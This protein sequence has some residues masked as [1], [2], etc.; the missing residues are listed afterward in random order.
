M[1]GYILKMFPRFSETFILTEI[2]E[3]EN[4]GHGVAVLSLK[5]PDDGRFHAEQSQ[6][7]AK[8][9]YLP[10]LFRDAPRTFL[11][12]HIRMASRRPKAYLSCLFTAM[13]LLGPATASFLYAPMAAEVAVSSGW[14]HIHAHFANLPAVTALFTARLT[15]LP[16][17][18]TA[19][20]KDIFIKG[21]SRPL[22]RLLFREATRV[23]TVSDY[24]L[25]YL[26]EIQDAATTHPDRIVRI[27]NGIDL[28]RFLPGND[29]H[30]E[31]RP[32]ILAIGRL[33]EKKGFDDLLEACRI[34]TENKISYRCR[35][36]GKGPL[37]EALANRISTLGLENDVA[38]CGP[39]PRGEIAR[40]LREAAILAAPCVEAGDG[41]R[42]GLPTVVLEAAAS[43][44]PVVA[45]E[46]TGMREAVV[47]GVTGR[48][49]APGSPREFAGA[50]EELLMDRDARRSMGLRARS[51]IQHKFDLR[52]SV[53][54]L[55]TLFHHEGTSAQPAADLARQAG[56]KAAV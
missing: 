55:E 4:R 15:G 30:A 6:V 34:L 43:G 33:V 20:A 56:R 9:N 40:M 1:T 38:L 24:N 51:L 49:V 47:D 29:D 18:F 31:S 45:T 5:K 22:L 11:R 10:E 54:M 32:L 13:R 12:A 48:V 21:T 14:S 25:H 52:A 39:R 2:L 35:I 16:F 37:Q 7:K 3:L 46:V 27:Y 23:V 36:V 44:V 41:N 8:V 28:D 42:D 53:Q 17:T 19:H 26:R 50:L